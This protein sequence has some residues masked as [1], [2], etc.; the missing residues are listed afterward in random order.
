ML[1]SS[2][3][4]C[5]QKVDH[6]LMAIILSKPNRF[7][8][9]FHR[10][11]IYRR[12]LVVHIFGTQCSTHLLKCHGDYPQSKKARD[13]SPI[14]MASTPMIASHSPRARHRIGYRQTP[15]LLPPRN[16]RFVGRHIWTDCFKIWHTQT[17]SKRLNEIDVGKSS[18]QRQELIRRWDTRKWRDVSSYLFTYLPL[19]YDTPVVP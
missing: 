19:I 3:T 2:C 12:Q 10:W 1:F 5:S 14:S 4:L 7:S 8:L 17:V 15:K 13:R 9:F 6:Q 18:G 11:Q 16:S